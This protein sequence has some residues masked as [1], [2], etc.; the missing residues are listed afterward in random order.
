MTFKFQHTAARRRLVAQVVVTWIVFVVS[1]H[2]RPKAAGIFPFITK[3]IFTVST[4]SRPKAAGSYHITALLFYFLFQHTAARRRLVKFDIYKCRFNN[5]S[6][7]SRPKAA[8]S[9][10]QASAPKSKA[11][12]HT[13]ARRRLGQ[14][15]RRHSHRNRFN[16]QPPEGGWRIKSAYFP[17][18]SQFQHTAARRRLDISD[19]LCLN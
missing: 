12:Q 18:H 16:T 13:A 6:T 10:P 19:A 4:H 8:G 7:H 17:V 14:Q 9:K 1:T 15:I 2:S 3:S 11:F 5:V